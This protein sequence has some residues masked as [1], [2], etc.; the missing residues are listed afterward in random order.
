[1][2]KDKKEI[3]KV[4]NSWIKVIEFKYTNLK[5]KGKVVHRTLKNECSL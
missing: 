1:M 3:K 4:Q 2:E 5:N